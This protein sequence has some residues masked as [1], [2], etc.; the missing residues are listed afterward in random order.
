MTDPALVWTLVGILIVTLYMGTL[1][2]PTVI[3]LVYRHQGKPRSFRWCL[4]HFFVDWVA[5]GCLVSGGRRVR[6]P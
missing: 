4:R 2:G 6:I 1:M 3:W 5:H